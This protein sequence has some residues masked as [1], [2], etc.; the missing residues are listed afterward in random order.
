[1]GRAF[2]QLQRRVMPHARPSDQSP[3]SQTG[4]VADLPFAR[5]LRVSPRPL[6][7][8]NASGPT[9]SR[10]GGGKSVLQTAEKDSSLILT[11]MRHGEPVFIESATAP[12][13][14]SADEFSADGSTPP[15][16]RGGTG[17]LGISRSWSQ[18]G[19]FPPPPRVPHEGRE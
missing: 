11:E 5:G 7:R 16:R 18:G 10:L 1:M 17:E 14:F 9:H 2:R 19:Q 13:Q 4:P 6:L 15:S 12:V 8:G 3:H